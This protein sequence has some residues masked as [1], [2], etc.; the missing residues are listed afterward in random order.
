MG[1]LIQRKCGFFQASLL[2]ALYVFV[3]CVELN[4]LPALLAHS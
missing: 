4:Y 3:E 2:L 1:I